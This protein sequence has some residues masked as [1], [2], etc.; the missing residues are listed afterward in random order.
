MKKRRFILLASIPI[1]SG[2]CKPEHDIGDQER[3]IKRAQDQVGCHIEDHALLR[4]R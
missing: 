2:S 3:D 4:S 1:R